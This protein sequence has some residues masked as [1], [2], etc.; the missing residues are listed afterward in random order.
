MTKP[1]PKWLMKRYAQLWKKLKDGKFHFENA[2]GV[3]QEKD[4]KTLSAVLSGMK[5]GGWLEVELDPRNARKRI[6]KLKSPEKIR[7]SWRL[8]RHLKNGQKTASRRVWKALVAQYITPGE[9]G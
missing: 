9:E 7:A 1:M 8:R 5:K 2:K 4:D 3:L 6:Y